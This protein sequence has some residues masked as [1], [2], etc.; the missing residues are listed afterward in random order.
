[1]EFD[2]IYSKYSLD[3]TIRM[4]INMYHSKWKAQLTQK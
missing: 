2:S 3:Y 1:M 4:D